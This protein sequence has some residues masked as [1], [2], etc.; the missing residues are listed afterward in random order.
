M[1]RFGYLPG[2]FS[3]WPLSSG[4]ASA[5]LV[6]VAAGTKGPWSPEV[7]RAVRTSF[8]LSC[9]ALS[10]RPPRAPW[11]GPRPAPRSRAPSSLP[12]SSRSGPNNC[13]LGDSARPRVVL[14]LF[15]SPNGLCKGNHLCAVESPVVWTVSPDSK[16]SRK[17]G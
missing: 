4:W 12:P 3:G 14:G 17:R 5:Y 16:L 10:P 7:T 11:R 1:P 2:T 13:R 15:C 9:S 6:L 8:G